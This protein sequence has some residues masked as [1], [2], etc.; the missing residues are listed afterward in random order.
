MPSGVNQG[1]KTI[2]SMHNDNVSRRAVPQKYDERK[3][4][5]EI[6]HISVDNQPRSIMD[7]SFKFSRDGGED[8]EKPGTSFSR[9]DVQ[10][11]QSYAQNKRYSFD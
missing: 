9:R 11:H 4:D 1:S 3:N 10:Q 6:S 5:R 8:R 2:Q 7:D